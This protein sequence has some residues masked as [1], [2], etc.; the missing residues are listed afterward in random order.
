MS[1]PLAIKPLY[2]KLDDCLSA[3]KFRLKRRITQLAQKVNDNSGVEGKGGEKK[4]A[5]PNASKRDI[6]V[7]EESLKALFEKLEG[8]INASIEKR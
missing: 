1:S 8:D 6:A 3:D 7:S 5:N 2:N 4:A